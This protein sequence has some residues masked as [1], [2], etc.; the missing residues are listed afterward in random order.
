MRAAIASSHGQRSSSVSGV[1]LR[2]FSTF[3]CG[4]SQ[5]PST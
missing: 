5:S 2:I 3:D 1:P 4:C